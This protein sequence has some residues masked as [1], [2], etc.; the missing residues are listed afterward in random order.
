[1]T[2]PPA[3]LGVFGALWFCYF[4]AIG[5]FNPFA[6]LWFKEL[7]FSTLAIGSLASL[8]SWTRVVAPYGW[9]WLGDH[10]GHRVR[11]VQWAA[12]LSLLAATGLLWARGYT[13]VAVCTAL[14]FLANGGVVP[15]TEALVA[16]HL[17]TADGVDVRRYGRVRVWGSVGFIASVLLFGLLLEKA[18]I[19][20]FP[21]LVVGT[22]ALLLAA[23]FRLPGGPE[24][25]H[26]QDVP[27]AVLSVLRQPAVAWFFASV[28]FT[29]LAHTSVYAFL[30]LYLDSLG[31]SKST[32]GLLWAVSVAAEI[33]FFWWQ[34]TLI[35]RL[36]PH[37]WLQVAAGASVLRFGATAAFGNH[38]A[39]LV[40]AQA[41][42]AVTFA[43]QHVACI[44]LIAR[45]FPGA[46]R[47]R[48]QALYSVLGYGS[49]GVVG[50]VTGGWLSTHFGFTAV[51]WAAAGAA[52][53][54]WWCA[55]RS[56]RAEPAG[57]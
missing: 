27:P 7:G 22:Y 56:L 3:R 43:A 30:S 24:P 50:G 34:G 42:H 18:G 32:V 25:T 4:A 36:Q 5:S 49:S 23:S 35:D 55:A 38:L 31:M 16:R 21:V 39:V 11:V 40:G 6:P 46:L 29:V 1:M 54:G 20:L 14:L 52:A 45:H 57:A 19:G 2:P 53:L 10:G 13:A 44:N 8:Q 17:T 12:G 33:A 41:L 26:G 37:A 48:G 15:Q 9:G 51:F 28:F 47:G